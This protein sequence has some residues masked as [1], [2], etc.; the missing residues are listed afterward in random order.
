MKKVV[1]SLF[2]L[3]ISIGFIY[4]QYD[5]QLSQYMFN[6]SAFNPAAVGESNRIEGTLQIRFE[7]TGMD[8][9]QNAGPQTT[10]FGINSPLKINNTL[11][12]IGFRI[13]N[14][15]AGLFTTTAFHL[16]YAYKKPIG[17]GLLSLGA[18]FG[19]VNIGFD[20]SKLSK[21]P[22]GT[23]HELSTDP[24]IPQSNVSGMAFDMSL[25]MFYSAT[26]YYAGLSYTHL[27]NPV[28]DWSDKNKFQETG[29]LYFVG[30]YTFNIPDSKYI[31]KPSTLV[32][33]DFSVLQFDITGRVEY[34]SKYWG[35]V[36][37]RPNSMAFLLGINIAG[38][39]SIGYSY[40]LPTSQLLLVSS[41]SHEI[42]LQYSFEYVFGKRNSKY[43]SIRI[44]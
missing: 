6:I 13:L 23:Y 21:I 36:S 10:V 22:I 11:H 35:A 41:G 39:L 44:L 43:K 32:K 7:K 25:G 3:L 30:G 12:G 33:T 5:S 34:D 19:F 20:G 9:T 17:Q 40:D 28:I 31:L 14:D 16:Q 18:D 26:A 38:G 42:M 24:A 29:T 4:S 8:S 27:N 2:L 1:L 37:Y 15:N